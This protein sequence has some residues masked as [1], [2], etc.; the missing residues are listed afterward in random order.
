MVIVARE[1]DGRWYVTLTVDTAAPPPLEQTGHA[2]GVD[3]GI[4]DFAVTSDGEKIANPRHLE[5]SFPFPPGTG[6]ARP[7]APGTTGTS[8]RPRTSWRQVLPCLPA[9]LASDIPGIPGC[10]QR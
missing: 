3:L 1:S 8:T 10:G 5:R 4:K 9:E 2:V 7:A 6:R